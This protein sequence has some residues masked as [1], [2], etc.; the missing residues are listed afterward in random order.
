MR[1]ICQGNV[2]EILAC[3]YED[4]PYRSFIMFSLSLCF[5]RNEVG[6]RSEKVLHKCSL[7]MA[8]HLILNVSR[9][10]HTRLQRASTWRAGF[11]GAVAFQDTE[12][13]CISKPK[14]TC[15]QSW[16]GVN[17]F[18]REWVIKLQSLMIVLIRKVWLKEKAHRTNMQLY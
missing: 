7:W 12:K 15:I 11:S 4:I 8:E 2:R 16:T 5:M 6:H 1:S 17:S 18:D 9:P 10:C 14:W 13:Y 3:L